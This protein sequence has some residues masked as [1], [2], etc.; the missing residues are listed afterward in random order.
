M[1]EEIE[2]ELLKRGAGIVR[3]VDISGFD[4]DMTLG[5]SRAILFCLVL[6]KDYLVGLQNGQPM[7]YD[8][9]EYLTKERNVEDLADWLAEFVQQKGYNAH[10][11][12]E[13]SNMEHGYIER[14]YIDPEL[15]QGIS[16]LPQKSIARVAGLG[17]IGKN[18]LL[19]TKDYGC[20]LCL[21]SVLSDAPVVTENH[22]LIQSECG[23]CTVCVENCPGAALHGN[24]WTIS[25]GR[26]SLV[27]VAK[28]C[29]ALQCMI[30]CPWTV[31]YA[32]RPEATPL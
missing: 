26:E 17:F 8:N 4:H 32:T 21:C 18:N 11:Q 25:G 5:Y 6:S 28:C 24:E 27:D 30:V 2:R 31:E 19:I 15:Q 7:D 16:I 1:N 23:G 22:P 20:A 29:C 3:F 12:S 10:S 13:K 14:A 9:D